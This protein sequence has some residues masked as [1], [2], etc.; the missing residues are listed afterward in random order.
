MPEPAESF[1]ESAERLCTTLER[2]GDALVAVDTA[3]LLQTEDTL[4]RLLAVLTAPASA[5]T[6]AEIEPLANRARAA[7]VRCR[8]LGASFNS[9]ARVRLPLCTG[10]EGYGPDGDYSAGGPQQRLKAIG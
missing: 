6:P 9:V 8:A 1:R 2:I 5:R 10:G 4:G 3:T 7:L